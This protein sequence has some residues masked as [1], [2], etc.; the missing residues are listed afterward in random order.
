ME[1]L[2][3]HHPRHTKIY[4]T[5]TYESG[6]YLYHIWIGGTWVRDGHLYYR[7]T[8]Y[9]C[10]NEIWADGSNPFSHDTLNSIFQNEYL[11]KSAGYQ[12]WGNY[13]A[14]GTYFS[15]DDPPYESHSMSGNS[16]R[17]VTWT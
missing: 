7:E 17:F 15:P 4:V 2:V 12:Y 10:A 9:N 3:R 1:P 16:W 8:K 13:P 14:T 5:S 11:Y 6:G